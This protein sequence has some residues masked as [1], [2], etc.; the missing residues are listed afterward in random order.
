MTSFKNETVEGYPGVFCHMDDVLVFGA[1][2]EEHDERLEK[3]LEA[4]GK[5]GLTLNEKC[6]FSKPSVKFLGQIVDA[7]G[8]RVDPHKVKA[9]AEITKPADISGV[10]RF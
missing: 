10:R 9:I 4:I 3:I 1:S 2:Q 8:C 5:A 7:S 6:E